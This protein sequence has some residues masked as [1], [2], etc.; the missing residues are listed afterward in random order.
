MPTPTTAEAFES[1]QELRFHLRGVHCLELT[2][3]FKRSKPEGEVATKPRNVNRA[4]DT[5]RHCPD[6]EADTCPKQEYK[7][8]DKAAKLWGQE[9]VKSATSSISLKGSTPMRGW[10]TD[11][12]ESCAETPSS[13]LYSDTIEKIDP[14]LASVTV[15]G[16]PSRATVHDI[17]DVDNSKGLDEEKT[18]LSRVGWLAKGEATTQST[19]N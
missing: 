15:P 8:V 9:T 1:V 13:S 7:F 4:N 2:K 3:G 11:E 12:N 16:T 5:S 18:H 17:I 19:C 6:M 14:L 10:I